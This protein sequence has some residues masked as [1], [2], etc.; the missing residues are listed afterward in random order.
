MHNIFIY[1]HH[2]FAVF[3]DPALKTKDLQRK[4]ARNCRRW[5]LL[6]FLGLAALA[7]SGGV[8]YARVASCVALLFHGVGATVHAVLC[9]RDAGADAWCG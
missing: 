2:T 5:A 3:R 1:W 6:L 9:W 8:P 7:L 4:M